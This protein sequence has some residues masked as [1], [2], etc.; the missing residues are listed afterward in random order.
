MLFLARCYDD[1]FWKQIR[2][3]HPNTLILKPFVSIIRF[4]SPGENS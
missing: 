2:I 3:R 1:H 4:L